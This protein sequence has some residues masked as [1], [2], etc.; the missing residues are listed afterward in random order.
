MGVPLQTSSATAQLQ[1]IV[2]ETEPAVVETEPAVVETEPAVVAASVNQLP[3]ALELIRTRHVP[4]KLVVFDFHA[5]VDDDRDA[6]EAARTGLADAGVEVQTLSDLVERDKSLPARPVAQP[7]SEDALG[8]LIY[9]PSST[10]APKGAT[11]PQS[12][13]GKTWCRSSKNWL[14]ES[15]ASTLAAARPRFAT[16]S[17]STG[18]AA[19]SSSR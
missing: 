6:L 2:V 4:A 17:G 15:A 3:T 14:G 5:E 12:N 13:M 10:G 8:L 1:T 7:D 18:W 11:Y 19:G 9:T 16:R